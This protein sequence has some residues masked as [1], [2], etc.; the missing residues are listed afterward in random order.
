MPRRCASRQGVRHRPVPPGCRSLTACVPPG[1]M[2]ILVS[3]SGETRDP[4]GLGLAGSRSRYTAD[5]VPSWRAVHTTLPADDGVVPRPEWRM[6]CLVPRTPW[7]PSGVMCGSVRSCGGSSSSRSRSWAG[8]LTDRAI[9]PFRFNLV[10]GR[11]LNMSRALRVRY[12][13]RVDRHYCVLRTK[14]WGAKCLKSE[15]N[16]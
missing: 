10:E 8:S 12:L 1:C 3:I 7:K 2:R 15:A 6:Y 4:H 5:T 11:P 9:D 13:R 16:R 14:R